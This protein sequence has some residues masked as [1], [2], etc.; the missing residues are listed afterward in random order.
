M[1]GC[2]KNRYFYRFFFLNEPIFVMFSINYKNKKE[3]TLKWNIE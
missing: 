1:E 2:G 3:S